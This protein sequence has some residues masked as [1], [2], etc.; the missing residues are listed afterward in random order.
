MQNLFNCMKEGLDATLETTVQKTNF[1]ASLLR[2][3]PI[4][5]KRFL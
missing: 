2:D 1:V 3:V 4:D 5:K